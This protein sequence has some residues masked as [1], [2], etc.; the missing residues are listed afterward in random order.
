MLLISRQTVSVSSGVA[1]SI[2][3]SL[4]IAAVEMHWV[5]KSVLSID[6]QLFCRSIY[7]FLFSLALLRQSLIRCGTDFFSFLP[8]F[9]SIEFERLIIVR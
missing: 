4:N 6:L 7:L 9:F 3:C 5:R 8:F 2:S 1:C